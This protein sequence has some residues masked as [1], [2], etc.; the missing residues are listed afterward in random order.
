MFL[1]CTSRPIGE[2]DEFAVAIG[3]TIYHG[4]QIMP[5]D[6]DMRYR[7]DEDALVIECFN[8]NAKQKDVLLKN[9]TFRSKKTE[10]KVLPNVLIWNP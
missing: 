5:E 10:K 8:R 6:I 4:L 9:L 2:G 7:K 1:D 3:G